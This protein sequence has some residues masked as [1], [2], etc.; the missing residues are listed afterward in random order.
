M[1]FRNEQD[2]KDLQD[3]SVTWKYVTYEDLD[4]LDLNQ[5]S[6]KT[7]TLFVFNLVLMIMLL[8]CLVG[9]FAI[10]MIVSYAYDEVEELPSIRNVD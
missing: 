2:K 6:S 4:L 7:A 9:I 8:F 1:K 10:T 3:G 5:E